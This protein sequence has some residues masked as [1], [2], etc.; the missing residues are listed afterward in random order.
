M[1]GEIGWRRNHGHA[2][3]RADGHGDH[4]LLQLFAQPYTCIETVGDD[5]A[6]LVVDQHFHTGLGMIGKE[7]CQHGT[8]H[9]LVCVSRGREAYRTGDEVAFAVQCVQRT[10]YLRDRGT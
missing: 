7:I 3:I 1:F 2:Q 10:V 6:E 5:V 9:R 4:V 8:N